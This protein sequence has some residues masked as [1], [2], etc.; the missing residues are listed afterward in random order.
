MIYWSRENTLC[1][2][3]G[4]ALR[5]QAWSYVSHLMPCWRNSQLD[6]RDLF[7]G[8]G[9]AQNLRG[10]IFA[11]VLS[12]RFISIFSCLVGVRGVCLRFVTVV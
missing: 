3:L 5:G 9:V 11:D 1:C 8:S 12:W 6:P 10:T 7:A 2:G 4:L